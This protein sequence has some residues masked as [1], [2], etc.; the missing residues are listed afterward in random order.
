MD[1]GEQ[2]R[3]K[4][5]DVFFASTNESE[6]LVQ[7]LKE[8]LKQINIAIGIKRKIMFR[9]QEWKMCAIPG[10]GNPEQKIRE[11]F[12]ASEMCIFVGVFRFQFGMPTGNIN[13]DTQKAFESGVEEEF[14]YAYKCKQEMGKPEIMIYKS[15]EEYVPRKLAVQ[16]QMDKVDKF[17]KEFQADGKYPTLYK[18]YKT[19][20]DLTIAFRQAIF[21]YYLDLIEKENQKNVPQIGKTLKENGYVDIFVNER[22]DE[23]NQLKKEEIKK[24]EKLLLHAKS[25][26]AFLARG[27]VFNEEIRK[28]LDRGMRMRIIMQNPWSLNSLYLSLNE[29]EFK[30]KKQYKD[31]VN[32]KLDS[33]EIISIFEQ[34]HWYNER[35]LLAIK[36]YEELRKQYSKNIQLK[37]CDEDASNSIFLSEDYIFFEPY[38]NTIRAGQKALSLF[39]IQADNTS[40]L[41]KDSEKYFENMWKS[42]YSYCQFSKNQDLH[43]NRLKGFLDG[44]RESK[45][46]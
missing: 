37:V 16:G 4:V 42:S 29:E 23:R 21:R 5:I 28:A 14:F 35:F 7:V 41:Y 36:G 27:I 15:S 19:L 10:A 3:D 32:H 18:E 25:C 31:Y 44:E 6:E 33:E 17:F 8:E 45:R 40:E 2:M 13:P 11:Q 39:E 1:E 46:K 26:H 43:K 24:T 30:S 9:E 20:E 12:P 22:N 38:L 34:S